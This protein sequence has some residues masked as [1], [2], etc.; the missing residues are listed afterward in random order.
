MN[1]LLIEFI[2]A[3]ISNKEVYVEDHNVT[4]DDY[5]I[6]TDSANP[7]KLQTKTFPVKGLVEIVS[8]EI[9]VKIPYLT[10]QLINDGEDGENKFITKKDTEAR[11]FQFSNL[12]DVH[13]VHD[14]GR[15]VNVTVIIGTQKVLADIDYM[16]DLNSIIV[17]HGRPETGV[18]LIE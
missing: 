17:S 18:I 2:M 8:Q 10:S 5:L 6:G 11:V 14:E 4:I 15:Y 3:K 7:K 16:E 13:I 12:K 9:G 1:E